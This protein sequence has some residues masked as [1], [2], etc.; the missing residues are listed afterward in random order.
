MM[1]LNAYNG[2]LIDYDAGMTIVYLAGYSECENKYVF[3]R[4]FRRVS[5]W[6]CHPHGHG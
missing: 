2:T 4:I 6:Q 1:V 3:E 5:I